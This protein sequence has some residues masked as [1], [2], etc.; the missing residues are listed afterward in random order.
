MPSYAIFDALASG[1]TLSHVKAAT[2]LS[3]TR[4]VIPEIG[5]P[6]ARLKDEWLHQSPFGLD[7]MH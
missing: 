2:T 6:G 1:Y 7:R 5:A 3:A 4:V